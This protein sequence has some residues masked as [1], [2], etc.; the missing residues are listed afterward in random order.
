[1]SPG[2]EARCGDNT[3]PL[4]HGQYGS[5]EA[6]PRS[7]QLGDDPGDPAKRLVKHL[8]CGGEAEPEGR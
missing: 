2:G 4:C 7:G 8:I 3:L 1:M 6:D 5:S